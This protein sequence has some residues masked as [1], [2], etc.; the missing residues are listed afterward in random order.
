[1][2]PEK[3]LAGMSKFGN[4]MPA[5]GVALLMKFLL[6]EK[7]YIAF[8]VFGFALYAYLGLSILGACVFALVIA[9]M[10]YMIIARNTEGVVAGAV[11][12]QNDEEEVL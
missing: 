4:F 10:Y 1:M 3:L 5:I 8:F 11:T 6:R 12:P 7:W 9:I 2:M